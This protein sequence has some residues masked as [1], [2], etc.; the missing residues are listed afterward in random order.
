MGDLQR[1]TR[2]DIVIDTTKR[3]LFKGKTIDS[4]KYLDHDTLGIQFYRWVLFSDLC[5][6]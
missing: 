1:D 5:S 3:E 4:I 6:E 2:I